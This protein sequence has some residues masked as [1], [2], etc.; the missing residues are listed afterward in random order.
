MAEILQHRIGRLQGSLYY[1]VTSFVTRYFYELYFFTE[2]RIEESTYFICNMHNICM[3]ESSIL[4]V[5]GLKI[6]KDGLACIALY[7]FSVAVLHG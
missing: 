3:S 4:L 7:S 1:A 5:K 6:F 2:A